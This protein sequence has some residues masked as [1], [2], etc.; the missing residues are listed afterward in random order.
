MLYLNDVMAIIDRESLFLV[1]AEKVEEDVNCVHVYISENPKTATT[2]ADRKTLEMD[3]KTLWRWPAG[4]AVVSLRL[5]DI[6]VLLSLRRDSGAPT[7]ANHDTIGSG[8]GSSANE[9]SYPLRTAYR[10][11]IEEV[12]I[13]TP[14]GIVCPT[15]EDDH[16]GFS[17]NLES[18]IRESVGLFSETRNQPFIYKHMVDVPLHGERD[19]FIHFQ[20]KTTK[21]RALVNFDPEVRGI[22]LLKVVLLDLSEYNLSEIN[23]YDGEAPGKKPLDRVVNAY[24]LSGTLVPTG[25]IIASWKSGLRI[26]TQTAIAQTPVLKDVMQAL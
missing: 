15:L 1:Q 7:Y 26:K 16:F 9:I 2:K 21:T 11:G 20:K 25:E 8:I 12:L 14:D 13:R 6:N 17:L 3:E 22:D 4:G 18:I 24:A 5:K 23:I 19:V 10:E